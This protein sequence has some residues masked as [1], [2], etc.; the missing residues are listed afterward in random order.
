MK[1]N[2]TA[3][4]PHLCGYGCAICRWL[5]QGRKTAA[6]WSGGERRLTSRQGRRIREGGFGSV[7]RAPESLCK[8]R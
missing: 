1:L 8:A 7:H 4:I 2:T 3:R 5:R 6:W